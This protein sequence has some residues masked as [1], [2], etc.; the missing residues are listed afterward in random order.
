M[1][2]LSNPAPG[3]GFRRSL[4]PAILVG[5]ALAA[6]GRP[7]GSPIVPDEAALALSEPGA[8]YR[9]AAPTDSWTGG[10][11]FQNRVWV[12]ESSNAVAIR[13]VRI[14][15]WDGTLVMTGPGSEPAFGRWIFERGRLR[16]VEAGI[17]YETD[18]LE[19]SGNRLHLRMKSPG[20]PVLLEMRDARPPWVDAETR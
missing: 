13:S 5:V 20:E 2:R 6:C 7:P 9:P 15:L 16:I 10:F 3:N 14:F 19:S 4:V 11:S 1:R 17:S 18:I 12:V 8:P